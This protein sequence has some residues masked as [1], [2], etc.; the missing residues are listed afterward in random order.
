VLRNSF[1]IITPFEA[2]DITQADQVGLFG[3]QVT[4]LN[5]SNPSVSVKARYINSHLVLSG[6]W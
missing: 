6:A 3:T 1:T 2:V 5:A 4:G